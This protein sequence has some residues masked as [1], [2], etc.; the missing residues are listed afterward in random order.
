MQRSEPITC[1]HCI[2]LDL[3]RPGEKNES[4]YDHTGK[5]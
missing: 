4:G 2:R 5:I 3:E 1:Y